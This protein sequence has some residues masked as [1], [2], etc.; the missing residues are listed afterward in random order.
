MSG[1]RFSR[2][3]SGGSFFDLAGLDADDW[4]YAVLDLST[5]PF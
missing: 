5:A 2:F 3:R 1:G 4:D